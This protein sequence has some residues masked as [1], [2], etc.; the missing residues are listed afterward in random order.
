MKPAKPK[1][2]SRVMKSMEVKE[3][4]NKSCPGAAISGKDLGKSVVERIPSGVFTF[5]MQSGGGIPQNRLII[6]HGPKSSGKTTFS[7]RMAGQQQRMFKDDSV[8]FADF[9]HTYD[10]NW[11]KHLVPDFGR[12]HLIQPDYGEQGIDWIADFAKTD[13]LGMIIVDSIAMMIPTAEAEGEAGDAYV[14]KLSQLTNRMQR[15]LLPLMSRRRRLKRPLTL[16]FINQERAKFGGKSFQP[17]TSQPGGFMQ[18]FVASMM[19]KFYIGE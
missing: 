15:I 4:V 13:D 16:I 1:K 9:E 8:L 11:A 18:G 5:D 17:T 10:H 7:L 12:F 2:S 14:G 19:V 6:L 3:M